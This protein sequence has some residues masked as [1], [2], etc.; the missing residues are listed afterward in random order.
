M[1]YYLGLD[2]GTTSAK[3]VA[4][5]RAGEVLASWSC[6]YKM[7]HPQSN[8]SEQD[9]DEVFDAVI[10]C[11]NKVISSLP[12]QSPL[13]VAFSSAMHGLMAIDKEGKP[14]TK[15]MIWADNRAVEIAQRLKNSEW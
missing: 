3:A 15:C 2:I 1:V 8:W 12:S 9:A 10:N 11:S 6:T 14:I 4:F 7:Y 13:F 5:S